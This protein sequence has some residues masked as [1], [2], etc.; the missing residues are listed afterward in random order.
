M[1]QVNRTPAPQLLSGSAAGRWRDLGGHRLYVAAPDHLRKQ[2][3]QMLVLYNI[4]L[5]VKQKAYLLLG[6][7]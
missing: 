5:R 4:I 3:N 7:L 6:K 1:C 2:L